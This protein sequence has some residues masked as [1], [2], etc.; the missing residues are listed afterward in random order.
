MRQAHSIVLASTNRHKFEEV[1]T[2]LVPYPGI[3]L[4]PANKAI[5]N[6]DKLGL[7]ETSDHYYDN[8][9]AKA[10]AANH[11]CHY[12][13]LAD[14]SGL[15]V[16]A[17]QGRP[18]VKSHRYA[19]PRADETQDQA[20][21]KKLLEELKDVPA[22]KRTARFV[23]HLA[24]VIEGVLVHTIG[25]L[26]GTIAT[27]IKGAQGF[28][29]DPLFIPKGFTQSLAELG[30]QKKN[31]ISHRATALKQLMQE[32]KAKDIVLARP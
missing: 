9:V 14:D 10:R 3:E 18:G 21:N 6:A 25:T 11:G 2:L 13:C 17:L 16:D 22:N 20:N 19:I 24:L 15:E 4:I 30:P 12:P 29:Y 31:E 5:R 1:Q 8:C 28:G 27:E 7:F 32:M 23:C 26:E